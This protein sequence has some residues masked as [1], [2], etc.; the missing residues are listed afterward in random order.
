MPDIFTIGDTIR[1]TAGIKNMDGN[2][3]DPVEI[4]ISVIGTDGEELLTEATPLKSSVGVYY[5][6]WKIQGITDRYNLIVKWE[7]DDNIK[8]VKFKAIPETDW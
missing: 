4:K 2:Y 5:Y 1:L 3:Y 7:W 6:D 8:R